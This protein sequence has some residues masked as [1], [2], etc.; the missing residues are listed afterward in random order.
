MNAR[1]DDILDR[2]TLRPSPT[3]PDGV[4][5][6]AEELSSRTGHDVLVTDRRCY[7]GPGE[8]GERGDTVG[9]G[10]R[11]PWGDRQEAIA[12][13][14]R[15]L[16]MSVIQGIRTSIPLHLRIL[17]DADFIAGR[18]STHFMERYQPKPRTNSLAETA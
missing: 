8:S 6:A 17:N 18:L 3:K 13:M 9:A 12:R 15:T 2:F 1:Y 10:S 5:V 4:R 14:K 7:T 11:Y 16:E